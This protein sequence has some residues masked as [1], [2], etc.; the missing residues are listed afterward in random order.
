M[1]DRI[2]DITTPTLQPR[3]QLVLPSARSMTFN[4][5]RA[6]A[7]I[8]KRATDPTD[9]WCINT[10]NRSVGNGR[11]DIDRQ[12][13]TAFKLRGWYPRQSFITHPPMTQQLATSTVGKRSTR[14]AQ[15]AARVHGKGLTVHCHES[16]P[17]RICNCAE[18]FPVVDIN[19]I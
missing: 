10:A 13:L 17:R 11:T 19:S 7:V 3:S 12:K 8:V 15:A 5:L 6:D 2:E 16:S 4:V 1:F 9:V 18:A 14:N